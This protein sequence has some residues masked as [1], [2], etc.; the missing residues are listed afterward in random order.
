[1]IV[2]SNVLGH[3]TPTTNKDLSSSRDAV[4]SGKGDKVV[5]LTSADAAQTPLPPTTTTTSAEKPLKTETQTPAKSNK[6]KSSF[7]CCGSAST[8]ET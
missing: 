1:M 4:E 6:K 8:H 2:L 7:F 3:E 5:G